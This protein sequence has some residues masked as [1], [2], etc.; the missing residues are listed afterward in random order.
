MGDVIVIKFILILRNK[1]MLPCN[2]REIHSLMMV[3]FYG[4]LRTI[5][6]KSSYYGAQLSLL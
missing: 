3:M 2:G 6:F 4:L 1:C 5:Q